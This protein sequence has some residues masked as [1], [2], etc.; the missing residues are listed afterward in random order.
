[1]THKGTVYG[2]D[3]ALC[4]M[5][6]KS[7]AADVDI[8]ADVDSRE[9]LRGGVALVFTGNKRA[10]S[11]HGVAGCNDDYSHESGGLEPISQ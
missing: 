9:S 7:D 11:Q 2:L 3:G 6:E 8:I 5:C 1:M 10:C 4:F